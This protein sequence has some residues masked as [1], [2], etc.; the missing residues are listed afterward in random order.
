M[1]IFELSTH[2][3][4]HRE[5]IRAA[6]DRVLDSGWVVLGPEVRRFEQA[7]AQ[8]AGVPHCVGVAS[9]TDALEIALRATGIG[10]GDRVASVANA[11]AYSALA[12]VA[13]GAEPFFVDVDARTSNTTLAEIER[14]L[15]AGVKAVMLTHLYGR[16]VAQTPEIAQACA[17][18]GAVLIED[19]AQAHGARVGGRPVGSFGAA[20]CFSFYPTKNL[21]A[22]GDG[23]AV[24]CADEVLAQRL[25]QLRQ[26]GWTGKYQITMEGGRNSRLDEMQAAI[27]CEFL[28][29]LEAANARRRHIA[30]RYAQAIKRDD[31]L[32]PELTDGHVMHL[33]VVRTGSREILREH[34]KQAGIASEVHYPV[35]DHRQPVFAGRHR[36][37]R[38][39]ETEQLAAQVLTLPCHPHLSDEDVTRVAQA[40]NTA[41]AL[42]RIH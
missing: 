20:A 23:G 11:G 37:M 13:A 4:A 30:E 27:L 38:L 19:C 17:R 29:G 25:R 31:V 6:V 26:Y 24:T 2:I 1:Q 9:G 33:F 21:G 14:A 39:P 12:A 16:P 36:N 35:P 5:G 3:A 18:A 7:F 42:E 32:L 22:L 10:A 40:V 34:L 41:P 28:P 15:A 8:F